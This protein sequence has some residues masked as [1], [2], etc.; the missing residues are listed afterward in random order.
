MAAQPTQALATSGRASQ[1]TTATAT[2]PQQ[3]AHEELRELEDI[4]YDDAAEEDDDA[5]D[6][7]VEAVYALRNHLAGREPTEADVKLINLLVGAGGT[8]V[9]ETIACAW[10]CLRSSAPTSESAVHFSYSGVPAHT[11][12]SLRMLASGNTTCALLFRTLV[13]PCAGT[14]DTRL[15]GE[16]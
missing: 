12:E 3:L 13:Q 2:L 15:S 7:V 8:S 1:T 6:E 14:L 16:A 4:V 11:P 9:E 10:P 5:P